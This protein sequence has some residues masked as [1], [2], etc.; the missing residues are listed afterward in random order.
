MRRGIAA[1]FVA[2]AVALAATSAGAAGFGFTI[3]VDGVG[4]VE[5]GVDFSLTHTPIGG[6]VSEF[7]LAAPFDASTIGEGNW[8]IDSWTST[9]NTDPFVQNNFLVTNNMAAVQTFTVTVILPIPPQVVN[10]YIASSIT[11]SVLDSDGNAGSSAATL[12]QSG[13]TPIYQ[14]FLNAPPPPATLSLL[15]PVGSGALP[16]TCAVN[17]CFASAGAGP[18]AGFFA[19]TLASSIGI[20][21]TFTLSPG[22]S[23]SVLSRFEVVPE[24]GTGLLLGLGLLAVGW[25]RRR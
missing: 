20:Q 3:D 6:G 17:G 12:G 10:Q 18:A 9:V 15:P 4:S 23:A 22:D 24:P 2:L 14:A 16:A 8:V 7:E 21:L 11:A 13:G 25:I 5:S 19:P 1:V